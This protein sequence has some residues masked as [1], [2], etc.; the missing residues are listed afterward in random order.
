[1]GKQPR[2]V[3]TGELLDEAV[4]LTLAQFCRTC[5]LPSERVVELVEE[6]IID[7]LGDSPQAWRFTGVCVHRV[8]R[9][10]RLERDL[11]V[12][13]AGAAL[14]LDLLDELEALRARLARYG[15]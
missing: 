1:M 11:G 3:L 8:L 2:K 9:V 4:V 6:G 14:V 7:P 12:N 10:Q 5:R 15:E 13:R